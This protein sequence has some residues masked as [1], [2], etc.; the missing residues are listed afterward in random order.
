MS[1]VPET[2][3]EVARALCNLSSWATHD[4]IA[5][6]VHSWL[7]T[8]RSRLPAPPSPTAVKVRALV[9]MDDEGRMQAIGGEDWSDEEMAEQFMFNDWHEPFAAITA[10][11]EPPRVAEVGGVV[12]SVTT[13]DAT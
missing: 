4:E 12:E 9:G 5:D 6:R 7:T 10:F 1:D 3:A 13:G 8:L 2:V 11:V